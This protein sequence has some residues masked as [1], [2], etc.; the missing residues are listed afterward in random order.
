MVTDLPSACRSPV[1]D[2]TGG[3]ILLGGHP[4]RSLN[5]RWLRSQCGLV[6]QEPTL[7]STSI[8]ENIL[9]AR[10]GSR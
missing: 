7:W 9:C 2:P 5:L 10:G 8:G 1:V 4:L 6:S 3:E